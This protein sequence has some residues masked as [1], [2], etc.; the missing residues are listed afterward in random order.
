M[1]TEM[2]K[3]EEDYVRGHFEV[4]LP[5]PLLKGKI[6]MD[7]HEEGEESSRIIDIKDPLDIDVYWDVAGSLVP[8]IC[9]CWC[10][11]LC[12]E[13]YGDCDEDFCLPPVYIDLDPCGDGKYHTTLTLPAGRIKYPENCE[14]SCLCKFVVSITYH[15]KCR[16]ARGHYLPGAIAG[17]VEGPLLQFYDMGEEVVGTPPQPPHP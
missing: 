10:V 2:E 6:W 13:C 12:I 7:Y 1:S 5:R 8:Y 16:D 17:F 15:T 3:H 14:C 4:E 9:G 11:Q